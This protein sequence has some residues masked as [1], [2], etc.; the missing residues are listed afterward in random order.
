MTHPPSALFRLRRVAA[1]L[2]L[3]SL[4]ACSNP[5]ASDDE[6]PNED[7]FAG[8]TAA[9]IYAEGEQ[10]LNDGDETGA[11]ETFEELERVHP[12]SE[13]AKRA[14]IMAA[15]S[16]YQGQEFDRAIS[17]AERYLSFFPSAPDAAFFTL[18]PPRSSS[19]PSS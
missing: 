8:R 12:Y 1:A 18:T 4:A 16:Y 11:A 10:R 5:F 19:N 6:D 2:A 14:M 3:M 17:A 7:P 9:S 15:F 13:W